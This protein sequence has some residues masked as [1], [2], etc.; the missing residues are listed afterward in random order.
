MVC[1]FDRKLVHILPIEVMTDIVVAGSVVTTEV[2]RQRRENATRGKLQKPAV[3]DGVEAMTPGVIDLPLQAMAHAFHR[4]QLQ[5]VIVAVG[6]G[7][8]LCHRGES[9]VGRLHVGE[10]SKT[11]R[12]NGLVSIDLREIGL[13]HRA[14]AYILHL[15]AARISELMLDSQTPLHEIRCVKLAIGNR[16]DCNRRQTCRWVCECGGAGK[17]ALR[18]T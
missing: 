11:S 12:A 2:P 8:K 3:R 13:I 17:L 5:T 4:R 6:S 18:E 10:R 7:R 14:S 9:W 1:H 16:R 15:N